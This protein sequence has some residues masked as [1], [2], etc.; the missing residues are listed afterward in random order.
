MLQ[1]VNSHECCTV[2][3]LAD[4]SSLRQI[5]AQSEGIDEKILIFG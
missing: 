3:E 5:E 4:L 1:Y 2:N